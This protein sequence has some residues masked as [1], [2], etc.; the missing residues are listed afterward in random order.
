M[1]EDGAGT[2]EELGEEDGALPLPIDWPDMLDADR[3]A[4]DVGG[5]GGGG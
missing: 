2:L 4:P 5:G 3:L 1:F